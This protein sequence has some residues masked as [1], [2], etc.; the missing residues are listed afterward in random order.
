M[1][2]SNAAFYHVVANALRV[3]WHVLGE[4]Y[5]ELDAQVV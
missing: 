3:S 2:F 1:T 5:I 4:L